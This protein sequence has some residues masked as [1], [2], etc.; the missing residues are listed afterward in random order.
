MYWQWLYLELP[1]LFW[2]R[3]QG[4][5]VIAKF[6]LKKKEKHFIGQVIRFDSDEPRKKFTKKKQITKEQA[7]FIWIDPKDVFP[8]PR[9][10]VMSI[11]KEPTPGRRGE[12]LFDKLK[13]YRN[14]E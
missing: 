12:L 2:S 1:R 9:D 14:I 7:V 10:D 5:W 11:L 4:M 13:Y 8:V 3:R 6:I